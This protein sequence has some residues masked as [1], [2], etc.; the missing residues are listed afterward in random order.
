MKNVVQMRDEG[1]R[2]PQMVKLGRYFH[3][4]VRLGRDALM[5]VDQIADEIAKSQQITVSRSATLR[6][7]INRGIADYEREA[8]A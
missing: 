6:M 5:R 1:V 2:E 8:Q 4:A 7:L 3:L